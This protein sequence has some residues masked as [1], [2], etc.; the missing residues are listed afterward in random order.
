MNKIAG[1]QSL[2]SRLLGGRAYDILLHF[3][4]TRPNSRRQDR[5][6]MIKQFVAEGQRS[7]KPS[8]MECREPTQRASVAGEGLKDAH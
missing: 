2:L 1:S 7:A 5:W 6:S 3:V 4:R 8:R